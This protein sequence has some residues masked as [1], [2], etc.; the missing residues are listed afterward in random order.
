MVLDEN[1][2]AF[3]KTSQTYQIRQPALPR[4]V[5]GQKHALARAFRD[6]YERNYGLRSPKRTIPGV[7]SFRRSGVVCTCK[8]IF[9]P[10]PREIRVSK[11][12]LL[13]NQIW[14][15]SL[16]CNDILLTFK[17]LFHVNPR[18]QRHEY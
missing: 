11:F 13:V 10:V 1:A 9:M 2:R 12:G 14:S 5:P 17:D 4:A 8:R 15:S 16:T 18:V 7:P 6:K 3:V